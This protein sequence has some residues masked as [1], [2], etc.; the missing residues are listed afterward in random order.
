MYKAL[1]L[2]FLLL[3][4]YDSVNASQNMQEVF[5]VGNNRNITYRINNNNN[6][7]NDKDFNINYKFTDTV[8]NEL[9]D[10][11]GNA[12]VVGVIYKKTGQNKIEY[13]SDLKKEDNNNSA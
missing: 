7:N 11:K 13:Y 8:Y 5:L 12:I 10:E 1:S 6:N 4:T 2:G 9:F 3:L